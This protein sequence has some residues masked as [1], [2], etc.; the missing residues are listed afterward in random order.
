MLILP[1]NVN[2]DIEAVRHVAELAFGDTPDA[3]LEQWFSFAE[4]EKT[5]KNS[6]GICLKAVSDDEQTVGMLYAQAENPINGKEGLEKWVIV[7]LAVD[8]QSKGKGIGSALLKEI[9][10]QAKNKGVAK[11]FVY[12]NK[13]DEQVINFY[14]KNNYKDAGYIKDYQYGK[15]N[16]AVFLLKYL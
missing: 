8:P 16:S 13:D 4:M 1:I 5:I 3:S 6:R 14:R 2:I 15:D 10:Q 11:M 9:E 12:T 7:I